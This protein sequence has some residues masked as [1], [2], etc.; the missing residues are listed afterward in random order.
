MSYAYDL[1]CGHKCKCL[2][3]A[4]YILSHKH[5]CIIPLCICQ[6]QFTL[7][8][9]PLACGHVP[10]PL[11]TMFIYFFLFF[12]PYWI[13]V[14]ENGTKVWDIALSPSVCL[15]LSVLFM[16]QESWTLMDIILSM[17]PMPETNL[18][19]TSCCLLG[20]SELT[21]ANSFTVRPWS[22]T[23]NMNIQ[24]KQR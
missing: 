8:P 12:V 13:A 10:I 19:N 22:F 6:F 18:M 1:F 2:F 21:R 14:D 15:S 23:N 20:L 4:A 11:V 3:S 16:H 9:V 5:I 17:S 7:D 24:I